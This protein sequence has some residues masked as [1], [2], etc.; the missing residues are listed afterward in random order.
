MKRAFLV[1][2]ILLVVV[3]ATGGAMFWF[4]P[5]EVSDVVI[6]FHMWRQHVHTHFAEVDG[7]QIHYYEAMPRENMI[8]YEGDKT[9]VLIHGLGSRGEDW[10]P[11]IPTLAAQGFHVYVPDLLGY[12]R[13]AKPDIAYSVALEEKIVT[14]FM[15]TMGLTNA[16]VGGWSMGGWV[17][18]KM[19]VDH[20]E[21]VDR[22]VVYDSA[23][24]YFPPTFDAGLFTPT[25]SAGLTHLSDMLSPTSRSLPGF[26]SRAALRKLHAN[27]WVIERSLNSMESGKDL[28]NFRLHTIRKPTLIVWG[29]LDRLIPLT[30]GKELHTRMPGSS[31]LIVDGCGHLAPGECSRPILKGTVEFLKAQPAL[32]EKIVEVPGT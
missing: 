21:M 25:D 18:L 22:L 12:G 15:K 31:M 9:L 2:A 6:R 20:P 8:K 32:K 30:V 26:V 10:S 19:T 14:D 3:A 1:V 5:L 23:G 7:Y 27:G 29:E 4:Y 11:M 16:D 17:A 24:I 28:L 13:S